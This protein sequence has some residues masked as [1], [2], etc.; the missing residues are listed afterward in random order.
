[1]RRL[2]AAPALAQAIE[3]IRPYDVAIQIRPTTP[4]GSPRTSHTTSA[5]STTASSATSRR[6]RRTTTYD[7]VYPLDMV[8]VSATGGARRTT[9]TRESGGMTR[10]RIGD[11]DRT[12]TGPHTYTIVYRCGR[13]ERIPRPRRAVLERDR[14]S[15]GRCRSRA[16]AAPSCS[17]ADD[18]RRSPATRAGRLE[19]ALRAGRIE[20]GRR[21]SRQTNLDPFEAMTM[22]VGDAQGRRSRSQSRG[23]SSAGARSRVQHRLPPH[24]LSR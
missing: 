13:A 8:S 3:G 21:R 2:L 14:R 4:C 15:S 7:R 18:H 1:M 10:I 12:I 5:P 20:G 16:R 24:R 19:P 9:R 17:P 22:V 11:P 6:V 23:W